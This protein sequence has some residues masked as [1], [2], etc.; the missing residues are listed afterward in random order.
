MLSPT[1]S[2]VIPCSSVDFALYFP[3][4]NSLCTPRISPNRE[5][6]IKSCS[7]GNRGGLA[8]RSLS[9]TLSSPSLPGELVALPLGRRWSSSSA[10]AD[11]LPESRV[12]WYVVCMSPHSAGGRCEK[13]RRNG[14]CKQEDVRVVE[15][16][17][18]QPR[19]FS[20]AKPR[21]ANQASR[22]CR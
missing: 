5:S 2:A 17:V 3:E 15:V 9:S 6:C 14:Q 7:T 13:Q 22:P 21:D 8:S 4:S 20:L 12:V 1:C 18:Q 11:M 16:V 10:E 19:N